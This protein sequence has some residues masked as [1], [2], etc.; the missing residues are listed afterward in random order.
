MKYLWISIILLLSKLY[1][2]QR[3]RTHR[4]LIRSCPIYF[5]ILFHCKVPFFLHLSFSITTSALCLFHF[6]FTFIPYF[7][8][9]SQWISIPIQSFRLLYSFWT[10]LQ[11]LLNTWFTFSSAFPHILHLLFGLISLCFYVVGS[12]SLFLCC[13]Y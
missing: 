10:N 1:S 9:I 7:L 11:H 3:N 8:H 5:M 2:Q 6:S 4:H 13:H 12:Y